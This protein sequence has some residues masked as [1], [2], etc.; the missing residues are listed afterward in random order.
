F[1]ALGEMVR[2]RAGL[3]EADDEHT[4]RAKLGETLSA[5]VPDETER[6]WIEPA[7]L[8]LLGIE[9]RVASSELF[10][11]WRTFFE[12]LAKVAPVVLVFE[13]HH[14][15]DAGLLDFVDH[16]LEWSRD[17]P[18]CVIT[19]ARP[20]LLERRPDWATGK[21]NLTVLHLEPLP[22]EAMRELIRGLVPGLPDAAIGQIV[23]R[24]EGVP[25]YAV[26]TIRMLL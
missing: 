14:H 23:A 4:T 3:L 17:V 11:A 13:D 24:A 26:E 8:A 16:L 18:L 7:L 5:F 1:W 2:A 10:A 6:R 15:A 12:R 20:E 21:R 9:T 22:D 19:L 25:L